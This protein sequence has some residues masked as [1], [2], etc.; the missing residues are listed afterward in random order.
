M[1]APCRKC[2]GPTIAE[3]KSVCIACWWAW[4][5]AAGKRTAIDSLQTARLQGKLKR[6]KKIIR[7]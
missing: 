4:S 2:A 7:T 5:N 3:D 6:K 1:C